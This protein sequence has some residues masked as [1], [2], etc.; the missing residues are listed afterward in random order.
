MVISGPDL[1]A[2]AGEIISEFS[3]DVFSDFVLRFSGAGHEN[4]G[5]CCFSL[6]QAFPM[7]IGMNKENKMPDIDL[8]YPFSSSFSA[9]NSTDISIL[10]FSLG[11][12][13]ILFGTNIKL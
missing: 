10:S 9:E 13:L 11:I 12:K 3:D 2:G 7:I 1:I 8:C 5:G 6:F 4:R